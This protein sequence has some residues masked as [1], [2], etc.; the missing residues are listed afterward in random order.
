[1]APPDTP[2]LAPGA[3][4]GG[5]Y[6]VSRVIGQGGMGTVLLA[7][8]E[9]LDQRFAIKVLTGDLST[10]PDAVARFMREARAAAK[11]QS[12]HVVRVSDVG[13]F[14]GI[15]PYIVMEYLSGTDLGQRVMEGG[16][17]APADAVDYVLEAIHAIAEAHSLGIVHRDLK[18]SNLFLAQRADGRQ[19]VKVL[20]FGIS[21]VDASMEAG[22]FQHK[23]TSAGSVL[24]S[25]AYMSPEQLKN[26]R[27]VDARAD[28]WSLGVVL[29]ELLSGL[30]PF[31]AETAGGVFTK[32]VSEDPRPLR[33]VRA[34]V[35]WELEQVILRCLRRN[36]DER[37]SD[38]GEL[39]RALEPLGS[40][41][42]AAP[43]PRPRVT[44]SSGSHAAASAMAVTQAA[45][46]PGTAQAADGAARAGG[47]AATHGAWTGGG[48]GAGRSRWGV[49]V[50]V[51]G[52]VFGLALV[53]IAVYVHSV[54][55]PLGAA[56]ADPRTAPSPVVAVPQTAGAAGLDVLGADAA[57]VAP[58]SSS[59]AVAATSSSASV[60]PAA[61]AA[62]PVRPP[63]VRPVGRPPTSP[64][65]TSTLPSFLNNQR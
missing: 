27:D 7:H 21:K 56:G 25:P 60:D 55:P 20:D 11:L 15:G 54:A 32:V 19:V 41:K 45:P 2:S 44:T 23:L 51:F 16:P 61:S 14:E 64:R 12:D 46:P 40:G 50:G 47:I 5:K 13:K 33:E 59:S 30:T 6:R 58:L 4:L 31:E 3:L 48:S 37:W 57:A 35:P 63:R 53:G 26:A 10:D 62:R 52:V 9:E 1:M 39:A 18:P 22:V 34:G 29:Y 49:V 38:V 43:A 8:H 28:I 42:T 24:G 65:P 36:P 17:L